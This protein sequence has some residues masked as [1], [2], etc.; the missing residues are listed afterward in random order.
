M[1]VVQTGFQVGDCGPQ[2][3]CF[4]ALAYVQG[5]WGTRLGILGENETAA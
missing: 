5:S 3:S 1:L 4:K 2:A